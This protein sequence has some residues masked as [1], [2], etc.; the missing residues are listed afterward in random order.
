MPSL[1]STTT[2]SP[3]VSSSTVAAEENAAG[4]EE[5]DNVNVSVSQE[6]SSEEDA[7]IK[8][9]SDEFFPE[10][11]DEEVESRE[12]KDVAVSVHLGAKNL[13]FCKN[14]IFFPFAYMIILN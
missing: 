6:K 5:N 11:E 2:V 12:R 4:A 9:R 7:F 14:V 8:A 3:D 13:Y 10:T 1:S